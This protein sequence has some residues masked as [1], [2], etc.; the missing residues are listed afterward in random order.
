[1]ALLLHVIGYD[2]IRSVHASVN[3]LDLTGWG[4]RLIDA[5]VLQHDWGV[6]SQICDITRCYAIQ[7]HGNLPSQDSD[8]YTL[9]CLIQSGSYCA[10]F[11]R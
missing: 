5:E 1:M 10:G 7:V 8:H 4:S 11:S 3:G 2:D 6:C 9:E